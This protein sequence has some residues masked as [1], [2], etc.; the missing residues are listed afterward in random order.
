MLTRRVGFDKHLYSCNCHHKHVDFRYPES[1]LGLLNSRPLPSPSGVNHVLISST[2]SQSDRFYELHR[3]SSFLWVFLL[4]LN[5][6]KIDNML[7]LSVHSCLLLSVY[8]I[9][10][11]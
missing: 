1:F 8:C 5:M 9:N 11:P 3:K 2:V 6:F 7:H 10:M 4:S